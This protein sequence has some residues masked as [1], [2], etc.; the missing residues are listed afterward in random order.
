[1]FSVNLS[2][3]RHFKINILVSDFPNLDVKHGVP[4]FIA[5][6]LWLSVMNKDADNYIFW[7]STERSYQQE[8]QSSPNYKYLGVNNIAELLVKMSDQ[9]MVLLSVA[10][11]TKEKYVI[12]VGLIE[13][14]QKF[15]KLYVQELLDT[16]S[17]E[18]KFSSFEDLYKDKFKVKL[19][20]DHF[21]LTDLDHLCDVLKDIPVVGNSS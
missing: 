11:E 10:P 16:H 19:M 14:R 13:R 8:F 9:G 15:L 7:Q 6:K 17:G 3:F 18:I 2:N 12:S 21:S 20:Y 1:M 5:N 4:K